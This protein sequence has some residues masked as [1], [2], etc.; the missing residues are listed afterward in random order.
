MQ[1]ARPR[2]T[3]VRIS[4][5]AA[6]PD[7]CAPAVVP[8]EKIPPRTARLQGAGADSRRSCLDEDPVSRTR[9]PRAERLLSLPGSG[10]QN[11][12]AVHRHVQADEAFQQTGEQIHTAARELFLVKFDL[13]AAPA[14]ETHTLFRGDLRQRGTAV[15]GKNA[16]DL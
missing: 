8:P 2:A 10:G 5:Q 7:R 11:R 4:R 13:H 16:L 14:Y 15:H 6:A 9:R 1:S 3:D 12:E